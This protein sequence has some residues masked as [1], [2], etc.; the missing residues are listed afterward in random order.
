MNSPK[1]RIVFCTVAT[2][3]LLLVAAGAS[4]QNM[5]GDTLFHKFLEVYANASGAGSSYGFFTPSLG[6][7]TEAVFDIFDQTGKKTKTVHFAEHASRELKIRLASIYDEFTSKAARKDHV[8]QALA[9]SLTSYIFGE[10][11]T[12]SRVVL[13]IEDYWPTTMAEY[14]EGKRSDW[15]VLYEAKFARNN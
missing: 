1:S 13:R 10:Y 6:G 8:R 5:E 15:E 12:A 2:L 4:Y 3:H 11:P 9:T 14:R 7:K